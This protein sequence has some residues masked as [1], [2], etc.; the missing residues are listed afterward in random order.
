[1]SGVDGALDQHT[2]LEFILVGVRTHCGV[3]QYT[4]VCSQSA[5]ALL[6]CF[7][8]CRAG[9]CLERASAHR[10]ELLLLCPYNQIV[11]FC[12]H[13]TLRASPLSPLHVLLSV[14]LFLSAVSVN[15][16]NMLHGTTVVQP[17]IRVVDAGCFRERL[18]YL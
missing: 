18:G 7:P 3:S 1:M 13:T 10:T 2:P 5:S 6:L 16:M 8:S 11:C 15:V 14:S 17:Y 12:T 9:C 4:T